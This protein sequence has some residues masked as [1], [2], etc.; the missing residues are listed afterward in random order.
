MVELTSQDSIKIEISNSL[1]QTANSSNASSDSMNASTLINKT[2][3]EQ[4][5]VAGY[6]SLQNKN[7]NYKTCEENLMKALH[8][9]QETKNDKTIQIIM[10]KNILDKLKRI[11]HHKILQINILIG[12]LYIH[13]FHFDNLF[14]TS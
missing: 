4:V 9:I 7:S 12:K 6:H 10:N 5:I 11:T 13:L 8:L 3:F 14:V 2:E 1:N